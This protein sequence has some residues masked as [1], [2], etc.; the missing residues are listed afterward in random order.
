M[1]FSLRSVLQHASGDFL[2]HPNMQTAFV[3][4]LSFLPALESFVLC[5]RQNKL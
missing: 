4:R 1:D 5:S 3:E 2:F